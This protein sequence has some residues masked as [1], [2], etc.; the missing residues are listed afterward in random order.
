MSIR[1]AWVTPALLALAFVLG[2]IPPAAATT[3]Q[4][5]ALSSATVTG[6]L[7]TALTSYGTQGISI[8]PGIQKFTEAA[9]VSCENVYN[10]QTGLTG[11][12]AGTGWF[13]GTQAGQRTIYQNAAVSTGQ[14]T[15]Y[16][17]VCA[18]GYNESVQMLVH[19]SF[20]IKLTGG[21][22][23][24][25]GSLRIGLAGGAPA[26]TNPICG[27]FAEVSLSSRGGISG[28]KAGVWRSNVVPAGLYGAA[29]TVTLSNQTWYDLYVWQNK[30]HQ[31]VSLYGPSGVTKASSSFPWTAAQC[32]A[33][34]SQ[35][36][37]LALVENG[38]A[39]G[40]V[41]SPIFAFTNATIGSKQ[42]GYGGAPPRAGYATLSATPPQK[43]SFIEVTALI[44]PMKWNP[45]G[46]TFNTAPSGG[47]CPCYVNTTSGV[48][49]WSDLTTHT[50]MFYNA[51]T[52]TLNV[53]GVPAGASV[54]IALRLNSTDGLANTYISS[55]LIPGVLAWTNPYQ[56]GQ[57]NTNS[58]F[59][60]DW[61]TPLV[62]VLGLGAFLFTVFIYYRE[63]F[64]K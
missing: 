14:G 31:D 47:V 51:T 44:P 64:A 43:L 5:L 59:A 6:N 30:S 29:S 57:D 53:T 12:G 32:G 27:S 48:P 34:Q 2:A 22:G 37:G 18:L 35:S 20:Y 16:S 9:L 8:V 15:W 28:L 40:A 11:L 1:L 13:L 38:T 24:V 49:L 56:Q 39:P 61:L 33:S 25:G 45:S 52:W 21:S 23:V 58:L 46:V 54:K 62:F 7:T 4:A 17:S 55:V 50:T 63:A 3:T 36:K 42:P 41:P 60:V 10:S 26:S 19:V